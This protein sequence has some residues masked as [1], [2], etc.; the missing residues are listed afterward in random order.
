MERWDQTN[1]REAIEGKNESVERNAES[2]GGQLG[3]DWTN[4]YIT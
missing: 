3:F 2:L 1:R 4:P